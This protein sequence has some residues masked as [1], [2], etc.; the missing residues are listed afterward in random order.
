MSLPREPID[1]YGRQVSV[2][3]LVRVLKLSGD[4]FDQ[5]PPDERAKVESMIGETFRVEEIDEYGHPWVR[6]SWP[7]EA[8]GTC[9]SHSV[10]LE[11]SE[12]ECVDEPSEPN[13]VA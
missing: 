2:G 1:R 9:T 5:L 12:M 4:W 13:S 11:P 7:D 3:S 6:K 8:E 10:A